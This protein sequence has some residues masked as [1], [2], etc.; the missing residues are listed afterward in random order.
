MPMNSRLASSAAG[1]C[2]V[3]PPDGGGAAAA[4]GNHRKG[5]RNKQAG[6]QLIYPICRLRVIL[7][8]RCLRKRARLHLNRIYRD[9]VNLM[10]D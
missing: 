5:E 6:L 3:P 2:S 1:T 8:S 7:L 4:T 10:L 9:Q